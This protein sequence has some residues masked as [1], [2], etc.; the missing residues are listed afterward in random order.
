LYLSLK[1]HEKWKVKILPF[2][3]F[4]ASQ[5]LNV[6]QNRLI[7]SPSLPVQE[8]IEITQEISDAS[9]G[10]INK[11]YEIVDTVGRNMPGVEVS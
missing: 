7:D 3:T 2:S 5:K 6:I 9:D 11:G 10:V 4:Q 8:N 1:R